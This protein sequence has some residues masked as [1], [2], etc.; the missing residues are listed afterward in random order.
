MYYVCS[1]E[2]GGNKEYIYMVLH[3]LPTSLKKGAKLIC[4]NGELMHSRGYTV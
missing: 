3:C 1:P 4:V 2:L